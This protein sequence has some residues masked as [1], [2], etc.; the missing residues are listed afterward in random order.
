MPDGMT[1]PILQMNRPDDEDARPFMSYT[2]NAAAEPQ[3][4][5][6]FAE[7]NIKPRLAGIQGIYRVDVTGATPMEWQLEYDSR[8]LASLG[9]SVSAIQNAIAEAYSMEF[10]GI[11]NSSENGGWLRLALA[12]D[13]DADNGFE[14][15]R[16]QVYAAD[17]SLISL[18]RLLTVNRMAQEPSSYYRI[19]GLNSIYLS[20]RS[21]E[22]ANQLEV[23]K[24]V[25]NEM[26]AINNI[27][28]TGYQMN[29]SYDATQFIREELQKIYILSGLTLLILLLFVLVM[30]RSWRYLGLITAS[31]ALNIC[32]ALI[33]YYLFGLEMQLYSLAGITISLSLIIDNTIVMTDHIRRHHDRNAILPILAA[34]LTTIGALSVIFFLDENIR[35][36]LQDFAAVV[37]IN[38]AVSVLVSLFFIP[39]AQMSDNK[40]SE[41]KPAY[42]SRR[43]RKLQLSA[44]RLQLSLLGF[45]RRWRLVACIILLLAFGLPVFMLPDKI[46][47]KAD[48]DYS[49]RDSAFIN[50][51][52][53]ITA[54]DTWKTKVKPVID[55]SLGG[56]LRLFVEKV[57]A[58]SYFTRPQ[59]TVLSITSTLPNG[60]TLEQMN[61]LVGRMETY[62]ST[63]SDN[64]RQFQ[65]NILSARQARID[66]FFHKE[67][68]RSG[69][70]YTLKSNIIS[71]ALELGG[72]SWGV[73][74]LQDQSFSND[75][76]ESAGNYRI[77]ML[78]YNYDELFSWAAQLRDTLLTYR[79]IR[80]VIINDQFSWYKDDYREFF[81]NLD[82]RRLAEAELKPIELF[83]SLRPVFARDVVAGSIVVDG[84]SERLALRSV[85]SDEYDVWGLLHF[86]LPTADRT[87]FLK[88][89]NL[90]SVGLEQAPQNVSKVD[91]QYRICIQY[92]YVGSGTQ[93][94]RVRDR[95]LDTFTRIMP[96]GYSAEPQSSYYTWSS[97]DNSQYFLL[98]LIIAIIY[99]VCSILFNSLR[100]PLAVIF[101][102]PVSYIGV[103]ITFYLFQLNF[104]QGGFAAFVLLC[105]ITVNSGIYIVNEYNSIRR[106]RP[107]LPIRTAYLKAW[108]AKMFPIFLTTIST[109]LG[110]IPFIMGE[111]KEAFWFPL[112]AGTIGG[113]L[114]SL[115][116]IFIYLPVFILPKK[117]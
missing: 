46:E 44:F 31:L 40:E 79:R 19:N 37:I 38:L 57:Y 14:P 28:P 21:E 67:A 16:I 71:K 52:N 20:I 73:Y 92:E 51:Y 12:P 10:L 4:I 59:E 97:G 68:E 113:L 1:Y 18:D 74:G 27:L 55:Y 114:M 3:L 96:M 58:G 56:S 81:F 115:V 6:R 107:N 62:L 54:G 103:F 105:G 109:V 104:D 112:A 72:G 7:D 2:I 22:T 34:T 88:I 70:P 36:N 41:K 98:L 111:E 86:P 5:Q 61:N 76:R 91:Q 63:F 69:F 90:A 32:I 101:L 78:G 43:I 11:A 15:A 23:A 80:E 42:I 66:V 29:I 110:F 49:Q 106:R 84:S 25:K 77:E 26:A 9:I 24:D 17:S 100:Q 53:E 83:S 13:M 48:K 39:A 35:L 95:V 99:F 8:Q 87:T 64:I 50:K 85:Q 94:D 116:G 60:A 33:F 82:K 45:L 47:M 117:Q 102:I 108:N 93:G 65:T 89:D 75:V 30:T